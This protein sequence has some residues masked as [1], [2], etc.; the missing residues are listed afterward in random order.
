[1]GTVRLLARE[2]W[3]NR[4]RLVATG[5]LCGLGITLLGTIAVI[6]IQIEPI[7]TTPTLHEWF[8]FLAGAVSL[9]VV[10][11]SV[12]LGISRWPARP[13][14]TALGL[15]LG[16]WIGYPALLPNSGYRHPLG[17]LLVS[18]VPL[19]V[20]LIL[21]RDVWPA[22]RATTIDGLS[23]RAG[24]VVSGM[25]GIFFLFSTGLFTVNPE[26]GITAPS[27][28]FVTTASFANPLVVWPAIEFYLP[29][30]PLAGALSVGTAI[31]IGLLAGLVGLNA[32]L[33]T[34]LWRGGVELSSSD[35][36]LGGFATTGATA[37]CCCGPSLY[38]IA[39]V[40]LGVSAS[41]LYWA[42]I[43]PASPLG[44]LFFVAAVGLLL[45]SSIRFA[46]NLEG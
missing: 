9:L 34:T 20:G 28:A 11:G 46:R 4:P 6:Q 45:S 27:E 13:E 36:L 7:G 31:L 26:E 12:F 40:F 22:I 39:S 33:L 15:A 24:I 41:P 21:W 5:F 29:S 38:A 8:P 1:M 14:Y 30:I 19:L 42:F 17:Y 18:L 37:C 2:P 43:D 10:M 3:K 44:T 32:A 25:F 23:R 16:V 35:G